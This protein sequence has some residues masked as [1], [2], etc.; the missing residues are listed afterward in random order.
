MDVSA[1]RADLSDFNNFFDTGDTL[2]GSGSVRLAAAS[3]ERAHHLER[4]HRRARLSLSQ[5]AHRRHAGRL[6]E[7]AQRDH[8][9]ARRR[10]QARE[11][12]TRAASI[13]L[14]PQ[15]Q[16]QS[17]LDALATS[18]LRGDVD[19]LDLSLWMP[20]LGMQSVP[21][22]GRASGERDVRGRFPLIDVRGNAQRLRRN[23]RAAD[24]RQRADSRSMPRGGASSSIEPRLTTPELSASARERSA[25]GANDPLDVT[26]A[27]RDQI[28]SPS[29][30]TT[31]SRVRVPISGSFE[32]TLKVG[33]TYHA[34]TFLAGFDATE[35]ASRMEFR[36]LRCS[37]KSVCSGVRSCSRTPARRS[38][39]AR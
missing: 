13:A 8:R 7:R 28:I 5:P 26:R 30:S 22:T 6:V 3:R 32:S 39:A 19:D 38:A 20:A 11:C 31:S 18:I 10:R 25:C 1:A 29:S 35:R 27:R 17:T 15:A 2:D 14:S 21:I 37:A 12:C 23:A 16:W 36:S 9:D 4:R 24:A 33:G 34:P